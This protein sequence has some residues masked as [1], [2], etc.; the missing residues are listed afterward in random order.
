[1]GGYGH[2][3]LPLNSV[4]HP[5]EVQLLQ[6]IL[7]AHQNTTQILVEASREVPVELVIFAEMTDL[8]TKLLFLVAPA[9]KLESI[10][11]Q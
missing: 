4:F 10:H 2:P 5:P 1:M 11:F 7:I 8:Q 9:H 3:L 6:S